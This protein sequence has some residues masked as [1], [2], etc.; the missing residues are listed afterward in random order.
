MVSAMS[1]MALLLRSECLEI[2]R[3]V[4]LEVVYEIWSNL[5]LLK[6]DNMETGNRR[7]IW[8]ELWFCQA[9]IEVGEQHRVL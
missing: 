6:K 7:I 5:S 8:T 9:A 3:P 1:V 2:R 4:V